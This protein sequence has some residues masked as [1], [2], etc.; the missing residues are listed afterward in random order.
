MKYLNIKGEHLTQ[1]G[2]G[3]ADLGYNRKNEIAAIRY[4]LNHGINVVDTAE[5]YGESEE[6]IGEALQEINRDKVFL[7][8]KFLPTHA[9][10]ELEAKSLHAS[11]KRLGT[12]YLDLYLLHWRA[13]ADLA[14]AVEGMEQL[15]K[16]GLIRH[17]GVSN[18]DVS[19]MEDLLAVNN[20]KN[21]FANED[22]YNLTSRG[23]EFDLFPWQKERGIGFMGYSPFHAVGW[24]YLHP[25]KT[26]EEIAANHHATAYQVMLAW[27]T[28]NDDVLTLPKAGSVSHVKD[29]IAAM[30]I[31]LTPDELA[32]ID[33]EFP[34]P[35]HKV[36][37]E[38]I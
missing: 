31:Q 38:K 6:I 17:W 8:S 32:V 28:R 1:I 7:V 9:T 4:G 37:L 20:G 30:D 14:Q 22:L 23:V 10:P 29:N 27:I 16:E 13:D 21:V 26:L 2:I 15:Q 36:P 33:Q 11:L 18:F 19:D 25:T 3:G 35:N 5:S 12:D 24:R 34:K